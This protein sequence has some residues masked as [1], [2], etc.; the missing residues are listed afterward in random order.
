MSRYTSLLLFLV[1]YFSA[2]NAL[3]PIGPLPVKPSS[4]SEASESTYIFTFESESELS[5]EPSFTISFPSQFQASDQNDVAVFIAK[6]Q[7]EWQKTNWIQLST[8][9]YTFKI[10]M[11]II[12]QSQYKIAFSE[13]MNPLDLNSTANFRIQILSGE[14]VIEESNDFE[15]IPLAVRPSS[16]SKF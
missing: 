12:H 4:I 16:K 8:N 11:T 3:K 15:G 9:P 7:E 6:E 2:I 14:T 5:R 1:I 10:P 13:I